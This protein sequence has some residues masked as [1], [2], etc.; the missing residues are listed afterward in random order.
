MARTDKTVPGGDTFFSQIDEKTLP[1]VVFN[2]LRAVTTF[3]K[4]QISYIGPWNDIEEL[5][6]K[7][8]KDLSFKRK[9]TFD[10]RK[11]KT[12]WEING[13][14]ATAAQISK[15]IL[16]HTNKGEL[17]SVVMK[18]DGIWV[19]T[20]KG[21]GALYPQ[22]KAVEDKPDEEEWIIDPRWSFTYSFWSVQTS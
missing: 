17:L 15:E 22:C 13:K 1:A 12:A 4:M 10:E 6:A 3:T 16:D 11:K 7:G 20:G 21:V 2:W 5:T 9:I 14:Q 19:L 8:Y 18:P